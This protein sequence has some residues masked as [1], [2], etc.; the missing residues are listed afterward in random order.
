MNRRTFLS[1]TATIGITAA[2]FALVGCG[3]D[4]DGADGSGAAITIEGAWARTSPMMATAGA[5]YLDVTSADGDT[6]VG[7]SVDATIAGTV[8]IHETR[9]VDGEMSET[10]MAGEMSGDEMAPTMEMVEVGSIV[11]PACETVELKPGGYHIMLLD[12]PAPLELGSTF[13]LTLTFENAGEQ[14]VEVV[15]ADEAP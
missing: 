1:L 14:Q 6:L 8:E 7:A 10:T 9:M 11:L 4:T 13:T 15:V 5:A 2:G 3:D 12:L